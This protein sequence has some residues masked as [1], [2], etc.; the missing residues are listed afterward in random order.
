MHS[1]YFAETDTVRR[2]ARPDTFRLCTLLR[3]AP[4]VLRRVQHPPACCGIPNPTRNRTNG[5]GSMPLCPPSAT[6]GDAVTAV[7]VERA[8]SRLHSQNASAIAKKVQYDVIK[9]Y[10]LNRARF[11]S[12]HAGAARVG[13]FLMATKKL[14]PSAAKFR[15]QI[16]PP[17]LAIEGWG[18][19]TVSL[20]AA[21]FIC[22]CICFMKSR[23]LAI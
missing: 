5:C 9:P 3:S 2:L 19:S 7:G 15:S 16:A 1:V 14:V 20:Y 22:D 12:V 21:F 13:E 17:F 23:I 8:T 11:A 4:I 6:E 18:Q 10:G